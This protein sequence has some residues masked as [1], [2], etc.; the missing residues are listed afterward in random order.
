MKTI[1]DEDT[2]FRLA[3]AS[4]KSECRAQVSNAVSMYFRSMHYLSSKL[5]CDCV[6]LNLLLNDKITPKSA[7]EII[8]CI[9]RRNKSFYTTVDSAYFP[10]EDR[11][12]EY[13]KQIL[14]DKYDIVKAM[15][16]RTTNYIVYVI[17]TDMSENYELYPQEIYHLAY[18]YQELSAIKKLPHY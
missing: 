16:M 18:S 9:R 10:I 2:I 1:I 4:L 6:V 11:F 8:T 12:E 7:D 5:I 13:A 17:S 3:D 15:N 14:G